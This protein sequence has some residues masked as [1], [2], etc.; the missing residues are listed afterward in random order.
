MKFNFEKFKKL[1]DCD[2]A[3]LSKLI[4]IYKKDITMGLEKISDFA[5]QADWE[6]VAPVAHKLLSSTT[7]LGRDELS[8]LLKEIEK[9]IK[10]KANAE[11]LLGLILQLEK[12]IKED[13]EEL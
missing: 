9:N 7:L 10:L 3:F 5:S 13:L 2:D 12:K 11:Q 4:E 8:Q 1:L 6:K